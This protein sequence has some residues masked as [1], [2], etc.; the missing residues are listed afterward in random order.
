M[1][2]AARYRGISLEISARGL[3]RLHRPIVAPERTPSLITKVHSVLHR[4]PVQ[5]N[6]SGWWRPLTGVAGLNRSIHS[7]CG[8]GAGSKSASAAA[9]F[10]AGTW[11][12]SWSRRIDGPMAPRITSHI[13][14]SI[15]SDPASR[16]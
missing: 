16:I 4:L 13:M 3:L 7:G 1:R 8:Y 11:Y 12:V 14:S 2:E 10:D 9:V 5:G 6:M 15:P